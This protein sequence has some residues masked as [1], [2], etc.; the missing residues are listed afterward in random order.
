MRRGHPQPRYLLRARGTRRSKFS[1]ARRGLSAS[2]L[3][4]Q[5]M[6]VSALIATCAFCVNTVKREIKL[7]NLALSHNI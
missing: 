4:E 1:T 2:G 5:Y 6:T 7:T 3:P